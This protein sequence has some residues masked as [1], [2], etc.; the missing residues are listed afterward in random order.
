MNAGLSAA[1]PPFEIAES[2]PTTLVRD[3]DLFIESIERPA[4]Y[5]TATGALDRKTFGGLVERLRTLDA[6][7]PRTDPEYGLMLGLFQRI[8]LDGRLC[9]LGKA[10]GKVR[11]T[12]TDRLAA[13]R[14]LTPAG[15]FM[16][17]LETFWLDCNWER[18]PPGPQGNGLTGMEVEEMVDSLLRLGPGRPIGAR[19]RAEG[20]YLW[21][22]PGI[23]AS[24]A[25]LGFFG[26]LRCEV[27]PPS[28]RNPYLRRHLVL[29]R[30]TLT[31]MG[32]AFLKVLKEARPFTLWNLPCRRGDRP[33][34]PGESIDRGDGGVEQET[35][36]ADALAL[37][38]NARRE[39]LILPRPVRPA[40]KGTY[41]FRIALGAVSR[42]IALSH[43]H[44]L[45]DLHLAIQK[46]FRFDD[47]HLYAFFMDGKRY[48]DDAY[49]DPR[50][51]E[52]PFAADARLADLDL[53][54]GQNILYLFD[55]G[56]CWEF[57]VVL[58]EIA[59]MPR[60]GPPR[61]IESKGTPPRQ[62]GRW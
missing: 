35:A 48:S 51:G 26:F 37:L 44:S 49:N 9:V 61:V 14:A 41:V 11:M 43:K 6:S 59:E 45:E 32:A 21:F 1:G 4:S 7:A 50:G 62:Y 53:Y 29:S 20:D 16:A 13:F 28:D 46:A 60:G 52:P 38:M 39:D 57:S 2:G 8:C 5:L 24:L 42:T 27:A 58:Q 30:A 23:Q 10:R 17:L 47:D 36:F 40:R 12:P 55:F 3:F 15:K 18:L 34:F 56:D 54:V 33:R 25:A 22:F 31:E 19:G